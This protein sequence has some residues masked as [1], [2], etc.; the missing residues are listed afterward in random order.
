MTNVSMTK[1]AERCRKNGL[2]VPPLSPG[3]S[4]IS[5]ER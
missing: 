5:C 4:L 2:D 3:V 1:A